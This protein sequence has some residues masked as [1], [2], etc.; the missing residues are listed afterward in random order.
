MFVESS[1]TRYYHHNP[2]V[3]ECRDRYIHVPKFLPR[4]DNVIPH[5]GLND[6]KTVINF[7]KKQ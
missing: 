3:E 5:G 1:L 6:L 2:P 4:E 7:D